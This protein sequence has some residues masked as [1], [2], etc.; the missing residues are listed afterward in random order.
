ML[1]ALPA[2]LVPGP[3]ALPSDGSLSPIRLSLIIAWVCVLLAAVA[4]AVLLR[5]AVVLSERRGA[6]VS[7]VTHEMRTPLT[8]FRMYTEMLDQGMVQDEEK[9]RSYLGTL[10][11]EAERLG[12]LVENV[13]AYARLERGRTKGRTTSVAVRDLLDQM[14]DRLVRRAEEAGMKL[15]VEADDE[16]LDVCAQTDPSAVEQIM[17]NLVDNACKYAGPAGER[18]IHVEA[19]RAGGAVALRVRDH[20]PGISRKDAPHLFRPFRKSARDAANSAPGVG[21]GLA[22]SRRLARSMGGDL[23]LDETVKDG[24][25]FVLTL[26]VPRDSSC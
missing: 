22:L 7:A 5:G 16:V 20:G 6:F 13:L 26:A 25:C 17:L 14:K 11:T 8:T 1:A 9:R 12:H 4:V 15:V 3:V 2:R 23:R 21:L 10:R 24:A 19:G 18:L